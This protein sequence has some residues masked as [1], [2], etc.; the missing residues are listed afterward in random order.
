MKNQSYIIAAILII[1]SISIHGFGKDRHLS[2]QSPVVDIESKIWD[3]SQTDESNI[4]PVYRTYGDSLI[5][6]IYNGCRHWYGFRNDSTFYL[7]EETRFYKTMLD[8]PVPTA[9]FANPQLIG[10]DSC[11]AKG[12]YYKSFAI[13]HTGSYE[14]IYPLAGRL[15]I[16]SGK[17][18]NATA[19]TEHRRIVSWL[20]S[21]T[22]PEGITKTTEY[23]RTRWFV[24]GDPLPIALQYT[25]NMLQNDRV[26]SSAS[27]AFIVSSEEINTDNTDDMTTLQQAL[28]NADIAI[29]DGTVRIKGDFPEN[30]ILTLFISNIGGNQ[31]HQNP[32]TAAPNGIYLECRLPYMP[33]GQYI[34][35][36]SA[37]TPSSR[38]IVITI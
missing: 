2:L 27:Q 30:T 31:F 28:D 29:A 15:F 7:G 17:S 37:G 12:V 23:F 6:E 26:I 14:S 4:H 5:S 20:I 10:A 3:F 9:A 22:L 38:K 18:I 8:T 24:D 32:L 21:D 36:I 19:I 13:G 16:S 11:T 33:P 1:I 34:L 25:E 35:T